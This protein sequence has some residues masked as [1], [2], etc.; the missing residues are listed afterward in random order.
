MGLHFQ[1]N[2]ASLV[3]YYGETAMK[4]ARWILQ[5]DWYSDFGT[6]CHRFISLNEQLSRGVLTKDTLQLLNKIR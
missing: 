5:Q 6:D 4:K 2:L 3:G 1:L